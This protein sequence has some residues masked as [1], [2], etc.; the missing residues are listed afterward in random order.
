[1]YRKLQTREDAL[2]SPEFEESPSTLSL[3][4]IFDDAPLEL[5]DFAHEESAQYCIDAL[6]GKTIIAL[7][8]QQ[9]SNYEVEYL[10]ETKENYLQILLDL[11]EVD[12]LYKIP[13]NEEEEIVPI[14]IEESN[15]AA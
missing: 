12:P 6:L 4:D 14:K 10:P 13:E 5:D 9:E 3:E 1:L 2:Q 15:E 7:H 8:L 11:E